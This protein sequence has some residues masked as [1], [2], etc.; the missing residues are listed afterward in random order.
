M[1]RSHPPRKCAFLV[2][3]V[4]ILLIIWLQITQAV[5]QTAEL[6]RVARDAFAWL[7][8]KFLLGL[9]GTILFTALIVLWLLLCDGRRWLASASDSP[10]EESDSEPGSAAA[11]ATLEEVKAGVQPAPGSATTGA[12][13]TAPPGHPEE[14]QTFAPTTVA[15]RIAMLVTVTALVFGDLWL[16]GIVSRTKPARENVGAALAYE[17]AGLE[18]LCVLFSMLGVFLA[19]KSNAGSFVSQHVVAPAT[20]PLSDVEV[21]GMENDGQS[22]LVSEAV[23]GEKDIERWN[24]SEEMHDQLTHLHDDKYNRVLYAS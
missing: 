17:L 13:D 5:P 2:I 14:R 21:E 16:S 8:R 22:G 9:S 19:C 11:A 4:S 10:P 3:A 1:R 23:T 15:G 12:T 7:A 20:L 6:G 18:V 24:H